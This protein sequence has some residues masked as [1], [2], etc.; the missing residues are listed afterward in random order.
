MDKKDRNNLP[1]PFSIGQKLL[2]SF[3]LGLFF[4]CALAY[5]NIMGEYRLWSHIFGKY[6]LLHFSEYLLG[7]LVVLGWLYL[8]EWLQER[9]ANAFC[10][11]ILS[12]NQLLPNVLVALAFVF[13]SFATNYLVIQT[14]YWI[15]KHYLP[16]Q[17]ATILGENAYHRRCLRQLYVNYLFFAFFIFYFLV[18]RYFVTRF[19]AARLRAEKAE[20]EGMGQKLSILRNQ[21]NPHFLFNSLSVLSTLVAIDGEKSEKFIGHLSKAY[22]RML[23]TRESSLTPLAEELELLESLRFLWETRYAGKVYVQIAVEESWKSALLV[24]LSG[25]IMAEYAISYSR[26]SLQQPLYMQFEIADESLTLSFPDQAYGFLDPY[27]VENL[28]RLDEQIQNL[29]AKK[30]VLEK[31][32]GVLRIAIPLSIP[33]HQAIPVIG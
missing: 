4:Y 23:E 19:N 27:Y 2:F 10:L 7:C 28:D 13:F 1:K 18:H 17:D 11:P 8:A 26:I 29:Q 32:N 16:V 25:K 33:V 30:L 14:V 3:G 5:V 24:P 12:R 9:F 6:F 21:V 31:E 20:K 15:Q 22:R